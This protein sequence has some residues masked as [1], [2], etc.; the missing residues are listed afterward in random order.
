MYVVLSALFLWLLDITNVSK[1][2]ALG[3][4]GFG[5]I[6]YSS[7]QVYHVQKSLISGLI[8]EEQRKEA[9]LWLKQYKPD[10]IIVL[11]PMY[12]LYLNH[13]FK[14]ANLNCGI[15]SVKI[16]ELEYDYIV[17]PKSNRSQ[18]KEQNLVLG[19]EMYQ[20]DFVKIYSLIGY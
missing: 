13:Y 16:A 8:E 5:I 4:A 7:V 17:L 12:K 3:L 15:Y 2:F 20:N 14:I 1:K 19:E 11:D 6:L 10:N 9:F 18:V